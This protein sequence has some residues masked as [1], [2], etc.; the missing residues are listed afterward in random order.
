[1]K[2]AQVAE[3]YSRATQIRLTM[4]NRWSIKFNNEPA[5][6][7]RIARLLT[8]AESRQAQILDGLMG[9]EGGAAGWS[10]A[11]QLS[12]FQD[13]DGLISWTQGGR[14][15][16]PMWQFDNRAVLPGIREVLRVFNSDDQWRVM[17]YF[18]SPR[19]QLGR[20]RSLDLLRIGKV[21]RVMKHARKHAADN[22][23]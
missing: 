21:E 14:R 8:T 12:G 18:L 1:M 3:S 5:P 9:A 17:R 2:W 22:T 6:K 11:L 23:W 4:I 16:Y 10:V 20:K 7:R 15:Y 19:A 13:L